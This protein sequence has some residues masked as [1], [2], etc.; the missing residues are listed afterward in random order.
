[1]HNETLHA[2]ANKSLPAVCVLEGSD[3]LTTLRCIY[4]HYF[5][6]K[7]ILRPPGRLLLPKVARQNVIAL[8]GE[9]MTQEPDAAGKHEE[10]HMS[11]SSHE[12]TR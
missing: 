5:E 2:R 4:Y 9:S 6:T 11:M 3:C 7:Q 1:M 12:S 10:A 8:R